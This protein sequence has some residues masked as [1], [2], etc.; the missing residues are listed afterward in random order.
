MIKAYEPLHHKYRPKRFDELIGQG[1]IAA[2]LKQAL[3][4]NRIAPA[5]LFSGPRGTGKTS[6]ARIFAKS[7]NCVNSK[8][9]TTQPCG[10]CELCKAINSGNALDIIEI[11]AASNTGVENIRELIERSR[12]APAKARWKVYVIDECHMLSTAAFNALLKTLE[13]PPPQVVFILA[14]TDPQRVLPTI[15]SRCMRFDFRRIG[16]NDLTN[17][18]ENIANK[19]KI[20]IDQEALL[21]IAKHS[22][23]GLRDAESLLDQL[24]LLPPPITHEKVNNL[25]GAIPEEQLIKL[26]ESLTNQDPNK[27]L[28]ISE[29][30]IENGKEPISILQGIASILRDLVVI[31]VSNDQYDL[32]TISKENYEVLKV[33]ANSTKLEQILSLQAKLRGSENYIRNSNQPKLW[34]EIQ[35]LGMLS[36]GDPKPNQITNKSLLESKNINQ[37][38][39]NIDLSDHSTKK[40]SKLN[41]QVLL[42]KTVEEKE[43]QL[44]K[45]NNLNDVWQK[46]LAMLELPSTKMLLTQ[47]ARLISLN[48]ESAEIGISDKWISMIQSRKNLIED[49]FHKAIGSP[50]TII[51]IQQKD[52]FENKHKEDIIDQAIKIKPETKIDKV[53][54]SSNPILI[55]EHQTSK[56]SNERKEDKNLKS[57]DSQAK[58]FADFF[59]GKIINL[60]EK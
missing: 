14:T 17:H 26:A 21:Q 3:K 4:S 6:S 23:G 1:P 48:S 44:T 13:E 45:N 2:T 38:T 28:H 49:A 52:S 20:L 25:T 7:L 36:Q 31:K 15:L 24:S 32:C 50:R 55:K 8:N 46:V 35:L 59:N 43:S 11:D 53:S 40:D 56:S 47:Q 12:F 60:E 29:Y 41:N 42:K 57:I 9:A 10:E 51:L 18:L 39:K 27:I 30:L 33:L 37:P 58:Q 22:Q 16:L 5:Y 19:E 54:S 34:L